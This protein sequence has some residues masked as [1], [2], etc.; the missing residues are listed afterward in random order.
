M[1]LYQKMYSHGQNSGLSISEIKEKIKIKVT[2]VD[3]REN[4]EVFNIY[5]NPFV[6]ELFIENK[7]NLGNVV[8]KLI[9]IHGN[10]LMMQNV[11]EG[12]ISLNQSIDAGFYYAFIC[13]ENGYVLSSQKILKE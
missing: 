4:N 7:Y 8:F 10:T 6:N 11:C 12:R 13:D 2:D 5:P 1:F 9:D 3:E